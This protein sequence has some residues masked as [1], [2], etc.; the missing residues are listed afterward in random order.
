[1]DVLRYA[2]VKIS[3]RLMN[4]LDKIQEDQQKL[5]DKFRAGNNFIDEKIHEELLES[6][7]KYGDL[8]NRVLSLKPLTYKTQSFYTR[9]FGGVFV[10][11]D[12]ISSIISF[13]LKKGF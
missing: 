6:A 11:R 9:A 12:F 7:K 2:D 13:Y 5:I 1:L 4:D 8:R 10:L 3:F